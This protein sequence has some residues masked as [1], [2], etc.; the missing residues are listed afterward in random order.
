MPSCSHVFKRKAL[1]V[2]VSM[3]QKSWINFY[4]MSPSHTWMKIHL[5]CPYYKYIVVEKDTS[6]LKRWPRCNLRTCDCVVFCGK[7][8]F[9][10]WKLNWEFWGGKIILDYLYRPTVIPGAHVREHRRVRVKEVCWHFRV[11]GERPE[12]WSC[13][14]AGFGDRERGRG[15]QAASRNLERSRNLILL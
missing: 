13:F 4:V 6:I 11:G 15:V 14:T 12:I 9:C 7:E 2:M 3:F 10:E 8:D 1:N 5:F